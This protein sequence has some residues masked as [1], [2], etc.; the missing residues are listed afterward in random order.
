L[1]SQRPNVEAKIVAELGEAGLLATPENPTPRAFELKDMQ[2]LPYLLCVCK[3][4]LLHPKKVQTDG[5]FTDS[6]V[7]CEE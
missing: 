7:L 3:V 2:D 5:T 4:R 6:A 1:I